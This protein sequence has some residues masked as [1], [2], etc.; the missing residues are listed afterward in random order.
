MTEHIDLS[1]DDEN[2]VV[3][4]QMIEAGDDLSIARE[5]DFSVIFPTEDAALEFAIHL[6]RNGLKTSFAPY[7]D[8]DEFPW[9]VQAH[10]FMLPTDE[11]IGEFERLLAD[12]AA[13]LGGATDG[14]GCMSQ[15]DD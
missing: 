15:G 6:L 2:A 9:Q 10:P 12:G 11:G 8:S 4:K 5:I 1:S 13:P 7:E 14:W 3:L